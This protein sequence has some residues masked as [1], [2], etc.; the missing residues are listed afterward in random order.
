MDGVY[1]PTGSLIFNSA[2]PALQNFD[3]DQVMTWSDTIEFNINSIQQMRLTTGGLGV[4]GIVGATGGIQLNTSGSQPT[5]DASVRG[6]L[7][8]IPGGAGVADIL[9]ACQKDAA[10]AYSWV[11]H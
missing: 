9:Q 4:E 7:W 2:V 1:S 11:T 5:C 3:G 8:N 10:D 6:L